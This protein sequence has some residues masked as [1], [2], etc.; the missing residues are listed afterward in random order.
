LR[1]LFFFQGENMN[2]E[3]EYTILPIATFLDEK[4]LPLDQAGGRWEQIQIEVLES[5]GVENCT[6][7]GVFPVL[8]EGVLGECQLLSADQRVVAATLDALQGEYA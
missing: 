7:W 5:E 4:I 1:L 3:T 6:G 2:A 8:P